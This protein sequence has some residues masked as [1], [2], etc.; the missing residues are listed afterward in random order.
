MRAGI[1][2]QIDGRVGFRV[3]ALAQVGADGRVGIAGISDLSLLEKN[4]PRHIWRI[5]CM[6]WLTKSTVRPSFSETDC[7]LPRHFF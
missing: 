7:I 6:L 3:H 1:I 4:H 2:G 5:A